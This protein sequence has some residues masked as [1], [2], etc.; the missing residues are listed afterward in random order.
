MKRTR[1]TIAGLVASVALALG[2]NAKT[3]PTLQPIG[4]T[5]IMN[6]VSS[7]ILLDRTG[8]MSDIWDEALGSVN[9]YAEAVGKVEDGEADD[10]ET[11]VTL[12]AFDYQEGFQFDVLRKD[13]TPDAWA[14]VTNDDVSPRGMTPLFDAINRTIT[15]AEADNP[16]KAVIVIMTDGHENSSR[17]V[18]RAGAKA[19]LDRAEARGWEV[20]FLGAEFASFGDADAV[21]VDRSKQMA[22]SSGS[23]AITQE[24]LAKKARD[25]G[26]GDAAEIEFDAEDRAIAEEEAVKDRSGSNR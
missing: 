6:A 26:K 8:S 3:E 11:T 16:E 19:A 7:Y 23:L 24:R 14:T 1:L 10:L 18:T 2:A 15:L 5:P 25:Y 22:V 21:G 12:A 9:A 4:D 20:V 13:V 17:E